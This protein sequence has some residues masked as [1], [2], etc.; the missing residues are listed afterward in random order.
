MGVDANRQDRSGSGGDECVLV[1]DGSFPGFLC[2][3]AEG[4]NL[5][6]NGHPLPGVRFRDEPA[7]LFDLDFPVR[8]DERRADSLWSRLC[9]RAGEAALATCHAAFCSDL[10][11]KDGAI[12]GALVRLALEGR[13]IL[14]DLGDRDSGLVERAAFRARA[15]AHLVTGLLRFSELADGSWYARYSSECRLLPLIGGHFSARFPTMRFAIHDRARGEAVISGPGVPWRIVCGFS[16]GPGG[17]EE[18]PPLSGD[19][20]RLRDCWATYFSSVA[21]QE[22]KNPGL[23]MSHMP[24]KYWRD[25]PETRSGAH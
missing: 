1:H 25:L 10:P 2:A 17:R 7:G 16:A 20:L 5:A 15:Q 12:F 11:G 21:I 22:R 8:R 13:T 6:K 14:D 19:E 3:V 24:R 4:I 23:Q 18:E 9:S